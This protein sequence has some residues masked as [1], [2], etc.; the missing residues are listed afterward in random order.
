M[1]RYLFLLAY[2]PGGWESASEA[3]R[4]AFVEA[5]REG[6]VSADGTHFA[7]VTYRRADA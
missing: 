3:E 1:R 6:H 5:S 2:E 4:Q 7:F